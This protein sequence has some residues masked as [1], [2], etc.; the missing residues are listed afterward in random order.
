MTRY[1]TLAGLL[2][3][4]DKKDRGQAQ[5]FANEIA[6]IRTEIYYLEQYCNRFKHLGD[7]RFVD[8]VTGVERDD[9][10]DDDEDEEEDTNQ[11]PAYG[12]IQ[13]YALAKRLKAAKLP[14]YD[15]P[16]AW[17]SPYVQLH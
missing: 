15:T 9:D 4:L 17:R 7:N 2:L 5:R 1:G 16:Y 6:Q 13:N 14:H 12:P 10:T 11:P 3:K 8:T